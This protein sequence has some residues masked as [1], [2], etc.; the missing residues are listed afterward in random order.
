MMKKISVPKILFFAVSLVVTAFLVYALLP[1]PISVETAKV[2]VGVLRVTID[3]E[4]EARAHD[5]YTV[6]APVAG[7]MERVEWHDGDAVKKGEVLVSLHPVPLGPREQAELTERIAAAAARQKEVQ[8]ALERA[9]ALHRQ[10]QR[11]KERVEGLA[12]RNLISR[13]ET[14]AAAVSELAAAKDLEASECELRAAEAEVQIARAGLMA[15]EPAANG[16]RVMRLR[17]PVQGKIL[18]ILEKSER[19]VAAGTPLMILGDPAH[20]EVVVD[21]L[22]TDAVKILPGM[23]VLLEEWGGE[24]PLRARVRT[25]EPAAFTKVSA[26]GIEEKRVNVVADFVDSASPL[27]DGFRV[28]ARIVIWEADSVLKVPTSALFRSGK[29]WSVFTVEGSRARLRPVEPGRRGCFETEILKGL[30]AGERIVAH[31]TNELTDG[32]RVKVR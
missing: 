12:K 14:E 22:S 24:R 5:H 7:R 20:L 25:V 26:L 17:A 11:E 3:E 29:G 10:A 19:V 15:V 8:A 32:A 27:G 1:S 28:V 21:V 6:A 18:R 4:G 2:K 16:S 13:R 23:P 9:R 31:P 30:E